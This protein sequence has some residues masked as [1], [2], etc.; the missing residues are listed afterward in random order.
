MKYDESGC[1]FRALPNKCLP[2]KGRRC[3]GGKHSKLRV[4]VAFI[5]NAAGGKV[6]QRELSFGKVKHP[7]VLNI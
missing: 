5:V 2:E 1:F 4:T 7:A 3:K 6:R